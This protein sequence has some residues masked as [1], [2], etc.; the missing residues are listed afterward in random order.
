M[1]SISQ[2]KKLRDETAC[3]T[4]LLIIAQPRLSDR[5]PTTRLLSSQFDMCLVPCRT[6]PPA[7]TVLPWGSQLHVCC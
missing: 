5:S 6:P 3:P 4:S 2:M 7:P 1:L